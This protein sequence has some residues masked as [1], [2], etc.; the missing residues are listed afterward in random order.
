MPDI[1]TGTVRAPLRALIYGSE[2][3]GKTTLA[4]GFPDPV[5]I[6]TE[7]GTERMDVR[8]IT[9]NPT[10][11]PQLIQLAEWARDN[12]QRFRT[13][14]VDTADRAE[15]MCIEYV[16]RNNGKTGVED[17]GYGKG[18]VYVAEEYCK[19]M[20][21]LDAVR[22]KGC[23]VVVCAHAKMRKQEL[24]DETGAFDRWE[25][26]LSRQVAPLLKEWADMILFANYK[27]IVVQDA[28]T[29]T[30]KARGGKRVMY[31]T[32]RP[33]WDAKNRFGLPEEL[34]LDYSA[35]AG[36][37]EAAWPSAEHAAENRDGSARKP[38]QRGPVKKKAAKAPESPEKPAEA[39][40]S[41]PAPSED[42]SSLAPASGA[43]P[44]PSRGQ[45]EPE[46]VKRL[47]ELMARDGVTE[48]EISL[49]VGAK[50]KELR[51][52]PVAEY[53]EDFVQNALIRQW[54]GFLKA[55][56]RM[57]VSDDEMPF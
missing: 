7:G 57:R 52:K 10:N 31:T 48:T 5:F 44:E 47:R 13:L 25:L 38:E 4:A 16:C 21:I 51:G 45:N 40:E 33:A 19:L 50:V 6:D 11:W 29:K 3:I 17:F 27:T 8:R 1:D 55:V 34:P 30:N 43:V 15:A 23:H 12:A 26:K 24:P 41:A 35:I 14:V 53:P 39:P 18:Y 9:P 2:G 49:L 36:A 37:V 32:H 42:K 20:D 54:Q 56:S 22:A 28:E 46:A